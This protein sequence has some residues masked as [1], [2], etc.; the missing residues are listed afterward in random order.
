MVLQPSFCEPES[1]WK[2]T[3]AA[4]HRWKEGVGPTFDP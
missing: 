1:S 3:Y 4:N 2:D